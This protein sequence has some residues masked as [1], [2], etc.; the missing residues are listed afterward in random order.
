MKTTNLKTSLERF[1]QAHDAQMALEARERCDEPLAPGEADR[2]VGRWIATMDVLVE[3]MTSQGLTSVRH[4]GRVFVLRQCDDID[5]PKG[6][7]DYRVD[8]IDLA[9]VLD[10]DAV[11]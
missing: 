3:Q 5:R 9:A 2:T 10:L 6:V 7:R 4:G 11:A 8:V 1:G